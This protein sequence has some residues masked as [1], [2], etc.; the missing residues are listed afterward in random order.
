MRV[1]GV[2]PVSEARGGREG[3]GRRQR[4]TGKSLFRIL[5]ARGM[6]S[7]GVGLTKEDQE[8]DQDKEDKGSN[9]DNKVGRF[10]QL[11]RQRRRGGVRKS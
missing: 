10:H 1:F 2:L 9:E 8:K 7:N 4:R 11:R 5:H 3:V 6:I